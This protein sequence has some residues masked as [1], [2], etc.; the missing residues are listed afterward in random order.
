MTDTMKGDLL[1]A[2]Q[3]V[4]EAGVDEGPWALTAAVATFV[5]S[6]RD[7]NYTIRAGDHKNKEAIKIKT[8]EIRRRVFL[9]F[10]LPTTMASDSANHVRAVLASSLVARRVA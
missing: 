8:V 9:E 3:D 4:M 6:W 5:A 10:I 1:D 7:S 2:G